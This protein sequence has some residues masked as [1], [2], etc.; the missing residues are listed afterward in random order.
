MAYGLPDGL[1]LPLLIMAVIILALLWK[2]KISKS[3]GGSKKR[4]KDTTP[5]GPSF[6]SI[7]HK[8]VNPDPGDEVEF[9]AEYTAD[10]S[11]SSYWF[12]VDG[13]KRDTSISSNALDTG[14]HTFDEGSYNYEAYIK[15][16]NGKTDTISSS[17]SVNSGETREG[18]SLRVSESWSDDSVILEA[19]AHR[20]SSP[21]E[22]TSIEVDGV[23]ESEGADSAS[24]ELPAEPGTTYSYEAT[25]VDENGMD[26]KNSGQITIPSNP[27]TI[28]VSANSEVV[29]HAEGDAK[30]WAE[31]TEHSGR[32]ETL[33]IAYRPADP[34]AR[35]GEGWETFSDGDTT[36]K[37]SLL[38]GLPDGTYEVKADVKEILESGSENKASDSDKFEIGSGGTPGET[39]DDIPEGFPDEWGAIFQN[40]NINGVPPGILEL[41]GDI[42]EET[43]G[44]D[45][46]GDVTQ[47]VGM[48]AEQLLLALS[49][50]EPDLSSEDNSRILEE[51]REIKQ[52]VSQ[53]QMSSNELE[54]SMKVV[55]Q[56]VFGA[57]LKSVI[58]GL[59]LDGGFNEQEIVQAIRQNSVDVD[60][61][62]DRLSSIEVAIQQLQSQGGGDFSDLEKKLDEIE[63][64]IKDTQ[65]D[66]SMMQNFMSQI[67]NMESEGVD[68]DV[69]AGG[70]DEAVILRLIDEIQDS[71]NP[72][73]EMESIL[74]VIREQGRLNRE[75]IQE[76]IE[77]EEEG[78]RRGVVNPVNMTKDPS[79]SG[80]TGNKNEEDADEDMPDNI[81][82]L[83][84]ELDTDIKRQIEHLEGEYNNLRELVEDQG[85]IE[86][87][88]SH[89]EHE[90]EEITEHLKKARQI[91]HHLDRLFN[92]EKN[93]SD[94]DFAEK[95]NDD[96]HR[97][98]GH[99]S[100][101][102]SVISKFREDFDVFR[103]D[104][105]DLDNVVASMGKVEGQIEQQ[106]QELGK[107]EEHMEN[108]IEQLQNNPDVDMDDYTK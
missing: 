83:E 46:R 21:I 85:E 54:N 59:E 11:I 19:E 63:S 75:L 34:D 67:Q 91:E 44:K 25:A 12:K 78:H 43:A 47:E 17:F 52:K 16:E 39:P 86:T 103:D 71:G 5:P 74:E 77:E 15:D 27:S 8:P 90:V 73:V 84:H 89:M 22:R 10:A 45:R 88:E 14:P 9:R 41:I 32:I 53:D 51:L 64:A 56:D 33:R 70:M 36:R 37:E 93:M 95:L 96:I 76:L 94:S 1:W 69:D 3:S 31:V 97:L 2:D 35:D 49:V 81:E 7:V 30:I 99:I 50:L 108:A 40:T 101:A 20:G 102:N 28:S 106:E 4:T 66:Q 79:D 38:Q 98:N 57:D 100:K 24:I 104:V 87:L 72:D 58:E 105:S 42:G 23:G 26:T 65:I 61:L 107:V 60:P 62:A 92:E 55:L 80:D 68:V 13:R 18:P 82:G 48:E 29:S 6:K